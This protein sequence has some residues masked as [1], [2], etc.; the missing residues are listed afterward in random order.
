MATNEFEAVAVLRGFFGG[1]SL[2]VH[3]T[4]ALMA[5]AAVVFVA[6]Y[7]EN[8][9]PNIGMSAVGA[10]AGCTTTLIA[11]AV[12]DGNQSSS[13]YFTAVIEPSRSAWGLQTKDLDSLPERLKFSLSAVQYRDNLHQPTATSLQ[14]QLASYCGNLPRELSILWLLAAAIG[15]YQLARTNWK[16]ALLLGLTLA[17]HL[18]YVLHHDMGDI[19]VGYIPT[20]VLLAIFAV[21]ALDVVPSSVKPAS[22]KPRRW[23]TA[24]EVS[25]SLL[26]LG[27]TLI[28]LVADGHFMMTGR[29]RFWVP[30]GEP[31]FE[32]DYSPELNQR[33]SACVRGLENNAVV[34]TEWGV[35]YS[36]YYV[37]HVQQQRTGLTFIQTY[38]AIGQ[39][40]LADSAIEFIREQI[41]TRPVYVSEPLPEIADTYDFEECRPG[42]MLLFRLR[43]K[44]EE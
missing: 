20:Y 23:R 43:L 31:P 42:G 37:A 34:F 24:L 39:S 44:T 16:F 11:F 29:P 41:Q 25:V 1:L 4:V 32:V 28:P 14:K 27:S 40:R 26:L 22:G 3:L 5:P 6:C 36:F 12:V 30:S 13:D 19:H 35:L 21:C 9:W 17:A 7:R 10:L 8:R 33:L 38:P 18:F 2:G 15:A